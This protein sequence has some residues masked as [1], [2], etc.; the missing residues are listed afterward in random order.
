MIN[1]VA[2]R[3]PKAIGSITANGSNQ[4]TAY[5]IPSV[6]AASLRLEFT[7]VTSGTGATLPVPAV[8][9]EISVWNAGGSSLTVYPNV[10]GT[11]NGGSANSSI[12]VSAG[13]GVTIWSAN[14]TAWYSLQTAG[15]GGGGGGGSG[16][17]QTFSF[18]V[19]PGTALSV[20]ANFFAPVIANA[21]KSLSILQIETLTN[22]SGA[23]GGATFDII[24]N[25]TSILA[26]PVAIAAG[27][28]S[29]TNATS[30]LSTTSVSTG[31]SFTL[32]I[33]A[34]GGGVQGVKVAFA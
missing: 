20:G 34:T 1:T 12:S 9:S 27:V 26:A 18:G 25:G 3:G 10:N 32:S 14:G 17:G 30:S 29:V 22:P 15:S 16:L 13:T 7:V 8:G 11:I 28:T 33:T 19:A 2:H 4:A 6:G 23:S 24:K 31:D 21:S 5:Q